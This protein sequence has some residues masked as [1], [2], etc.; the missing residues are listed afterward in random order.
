M[1]T[2]RNWMSSPVVVVD[3]AS[4]NTSGWFVAMVEYGVS[5]IATD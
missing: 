4:T 2:V 5:L 3:P 1:N